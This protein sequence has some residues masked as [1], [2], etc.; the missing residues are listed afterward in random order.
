MRKW[1]RWTLVGAAFGFSLAVWSRLPDQ[2]PTHWGANGEANGFSS[3]T[4][5]VLLLPT[6][7]AVMALLLPMLPKIDPRGAN[8]EKF[9]PTFEIVID[10]IITAM[11]VLHVAMLGTS[12]GWPISMQRVTP[13]I[14]GGLFILLGNVMP[15]ARPNWMFGIRTPWTLTNDRVWERTHRLG[16]TMFV[17]GGIVM[18]ASAWLPATAFFPTIMSV[19]MISAIIPVVYSYVIWKREAAR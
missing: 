7:I 17:V 13:F 10:A 18:L 19:T 9:R 6:I 2:M 15:R 4:F 12:L 8:Y 3:R 1:Y 14:I 5:A 16:G 11:V